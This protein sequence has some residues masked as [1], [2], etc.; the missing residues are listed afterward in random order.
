MEIQGLGAMGSAFS[1]Q[2]TTLTEEERAR[3]EAILAKYDPENMT[4]EDRKALMGELKSSGLPRCRET[5]EAIKEAGFEL[6]KPP[7]D[8]GMPEGVKA[9]GAGTMNP[10][11]VNLIKQFKSGEITADDFMAQLEEMK[12][13]LAGNVGLLIDQE[14]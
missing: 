7:K 12:N 10:E 1:A 4:E 5:F 11:F 14:V 9:Q 8:K 6:P 3:L 13:D 2:Q